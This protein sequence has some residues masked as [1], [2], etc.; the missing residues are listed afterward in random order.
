MLLVLMLDI[1]TVKVLNILLV[2]N[3]DDDDVNLLP[4]RSWYVAHFLNPVPAVP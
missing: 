2:M 3:N 4:V 1:W